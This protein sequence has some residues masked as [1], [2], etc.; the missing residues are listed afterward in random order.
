MPLAARFLITESI[1]GC[2]LVFRVLSERLHHYHFRT[3]VIEAHVDL[4][5]VLDSLN[6]DVLL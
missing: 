6:R 5:K 4:C 2:I 3:R 1:L